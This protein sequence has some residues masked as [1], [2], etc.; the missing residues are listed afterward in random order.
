MKT[1]LSRNCSNKTLRD[2]ELFQF[3]AVC[4]ILRLLEA[5]PEHRVGNDLELI[6]FD[7]GYALEKY[8]KTRLKTKKKAFY[9]SVGKIYFV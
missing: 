3:S 9:F 2:Q 7:G 4:V 8:F 5:Y 6:Y 1:K